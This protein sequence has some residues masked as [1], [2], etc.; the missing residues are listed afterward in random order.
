MDYGMT[1]RAS[2]STTTDADRNPVW[3]RTLDVITVAAPVVLFATIYIGCLPYRLQSW[4][5]DGVF[6]S[7]A[8]GALLVTAFGVFGWYHRFD[9][10]IGRLQEKFPVL[11]RR[12]VQYALSLLPTLP[13]ILIRFFVR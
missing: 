3:K 11:R 12:S 5:P 13:I 7:I 4:L 8:F 2:Q 1:D 10:A 9:P 6:F